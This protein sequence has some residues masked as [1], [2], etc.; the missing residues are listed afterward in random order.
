MTDSIL[1][2][3]FKRPLSMALSLMCSVIMIGCHTQSDPD[4]S[5]SGGAHSSSEVRTG[6]DGD[7][8]SAGGAAAGHEMGGGEPMGGGEMIGGDEV[9]GGDKPMGGGGSM[10]GGEDDSSMV[11]PSCDALQPEV[12]AL[13]WPSDFYL[14]PMSDLL[15]REDSSSWIPTSGQSRALDFSIDTLPS[16]LRGA[17][18][19][20]REYRRLDG[21]GLQAVGMALLPRIQRDD[22]PDERHLAQ[23][24]DSASKIALIELSDDEPKRLPCWAEWDQRARTPHRALMFIRPAVLLKEDTEYAYVIRDA[25]DGDGALIEPSPAFLSLRDGAGVNPQ[26]D[27][28]VSAARRAHFEALF[29]AT[30]RLGIP[31]AELTLA[32]RFRTATQ[33]SLTGAMVQIRDDGLAQLGPNGPE[34][35]VDTVSAWRHPD[36][37]DDET[38]SAKP[39]IG[40]EVTGRFIVPSFIEPDEDVGVLGT[41][42]RLHRNAE[43]AP[44]S[45]GEREARFW[46]RVPHSVLSGREAGVV[47]YGHGQLYSGA[48]VRMGD[49]GPVAEEGGYIFIGTDLSGMSEDEIGTVPIVL[50]DLSRFRWISDRL[51]QGLFNTLALVRAVKRGGLSALTP[52]RERNVEINL[53]RVVYGGI[54]QGGIFGAS[55]LALS[56]EITRGHLGVPGQHYF[57]LLGRSRNFLS[58]FSILELSYPDPIDQWIG[59]AAAQLL[60]NTTDPVSYYPHLSVNP[61]PNTPPHVVLIAPAQGDPQVSPLTVENVARSGLGIAVMA[62]YGSD[63]TLPLIDEVNYPHV[64]SALVNWSYDVPRPPA[65]NAPPTADEDP[66][67][68]PRNDPLHTQQMIHFW[69]TGEIIDVCGGRVCGAPEE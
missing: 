61:L 57:T 28:Q 4:Q 16:N 12:C 34:L 66:H 23:S 36:D 39:Y 54:S 51:H 55:I 6:G 7:A 47:I 32:W 22:F 11:R 10:S 38:L 20:A 59:L 60:W 15:A 50:G 31:R 62:P 68:R 33:T 1:P 42:V 19:Q 46:A 2:S 65:G 43:G 63:F 67:D 17:P 27:R 13:P 24:L 56:Q 44:Q 41:G 35:I 48:E 18:H 26:G 53:D 8:S 29:N 30:E 64:G 21:Y 49:K 5:I 45:I 9:M 58:L 14:T 69:E 25:R 3:Y 52:L 37:E 40:L